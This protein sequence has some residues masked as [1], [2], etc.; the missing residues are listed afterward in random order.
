MITTK[1]TT[2]STNWVKADVD[3]AYV[4]L[5]QVKDPEE[6][7][8][9]VWGRHKLQPTKIGSTED[10]RILTLVVVLDV[11]VPYFWWWLATNLL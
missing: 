11:V 3:M 7:P 8:I 1:T 5:E 2:T 10:L 6:M 4:I 9:L